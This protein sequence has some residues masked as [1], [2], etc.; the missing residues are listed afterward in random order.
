M[1]FPCYKDFHLLPNFYDSLII[2][3]REWNAQKL[4]TF[5]LSTHSLF[6]SLR[7]HFLCEIQN[8]WVLLK[9]YLEKVKDLETG[10]QFSTIGIYMNIYQSFVPNFIEFLLLKLSKWNSQKLGTNS[11]SA[12]L[13]CF[14]LFNH[15]LW[16]SQKLGTNLCTKSIC[17]QCYKDFHLLPN[18]Y[19]SLNIRSGEW[20]AQK[21]GTF[22]L[23]THSLYISLHYHCFCKIQNNWVLLKIYL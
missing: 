7:H 13:V 19:D 8:N 3:S 23:S 17:F 12:Q 10:H 21:L 5:M 16:N 20:N 1:Y 22:M 15:C 11:K 2:R 14:P 4:G 18:F 9:M 6:I